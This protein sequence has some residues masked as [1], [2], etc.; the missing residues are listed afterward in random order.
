M[1]S[2]GQ[3]FIAEMPSASSSAASASGSLFQAHRSSSGPGRPW[4]SYGGRPYAGPP[5]V[6]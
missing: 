2:N 5:Q 6:L 3:I 1:S 4:T